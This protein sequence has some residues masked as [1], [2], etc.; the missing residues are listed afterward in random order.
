MPD[1][2]VVPQF[3]DVEDKILGPLSVRQFVILLLVLLTDALLYKLLT[4]G[5]F[6]MVGIPVIIIGG[7]FAFVKIN[8]QPFHY[9]LL[10]IVQTL[11]KPG[12]RVWDKHLTDGEVR[13]FITEEAAPPPPPPVRKAALT[14]SRLSELSLVVNTGGVY[15]PE[16]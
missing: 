6:M 9:A 8:G 13:S 2:F 7:V 15:N 4:F 11:R 16:E 1:Q 3:I 14:S 5:K 10:N 12:I